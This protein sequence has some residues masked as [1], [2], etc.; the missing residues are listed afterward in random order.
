MAP[1]A[2]QATHQALGEDLQWSWHTGSETADAL[3]VP[4]ATLFD[5]PSYAVH[6]VSGRETPHSARF[7]RRCHTLMVFDRGS[8]V[9]GE[10]RIAG[11]QPAPS[12]PLDQGIDVVPA[13]QDFH[14]LAGP[15][16]NVECILI[17]VGERPCAA[18][19]DSNGSR[20]ALH[21][22]VNLGGGLLLPLADKLR[23]LCRDDARYLDRLHLEALIDL[24]V[25]EIRQV[26][27]D[28][29]HRPGRCAGGLSARARRITRDFL[30]QNLDQKI[31]LETLAAQVGLSRFHFT[32]AFKTS[33]GMPPYRYLLNLRIRKAADLLRSSQMPVTTIALEVGFSCPSEFARAFRQVMN[34]TPRDF[35]LVN[36]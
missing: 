6:R 1:I 4:I 26:Q 28:V 10:R 5:G 18:I 3:Q 23:E 33:F 15:G 8:F 12:G 29:A 13:D 22:A 14:G 7:R 2:P 27:H 19:D 35:R 32:R 31:D 21:P 36:R 11:L 34:C 17:S 9:D 24:L 30:A 25:L 20:P 16:S